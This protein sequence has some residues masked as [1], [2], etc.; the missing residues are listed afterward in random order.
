MN[1]TLPI[2]IVAG[3]LA[4][5]MHPI[6]E[7]IPKCLIDIHGKPLIE[8]QLDV[9]KKQGFKEIIFC[10][11]H[12]AEK[13]QE[14]FGDGFKWGLNIQY[15]M[16][17][18]ILL[19]TAGAVKRAGALLPDHFMVFYGDTIS[20][21][22]FNEFVKFHFQKK[23]T[24]SISLREKPKG[25]KSSSLI[26]LEQNKI[27]QFIEKPSQKMINQYD[28]SGTKTYI[29][30]GIFIINRSTLNLIPKNQKYDFSNDLFPLLIKSKNQ[31]N[32]YI[33]KD[34]Y[35]E[36]GRMEKYNNLLQE[37]TLKTDH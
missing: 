29:N 23:S 16:D 15:S 37:E 24:V 10:V 36:I 3:G 32:G 13:V 31:M 8:H 26:T 19:G 28:N 9:F 14:Y 7:Q 18:N 34:F 17:G 4:T 2:V 33:S 12:L 11:A 30:N 22:N 20:K 25:Y 6:C 1:N 21:Q 27:T 35:R 5:R